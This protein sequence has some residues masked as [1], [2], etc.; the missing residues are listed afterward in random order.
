[1]RASFGVAI[2][3]QDGHNR[4]A[5]LNNAD[6]AMNRAK[7]TRGEP[8]CYYEQ[9]MDEHARTRRRIAGDLHNALAHE[10]LCLFY[11]PQHSVRT[12]ALTGYEALVRWRHRCA[13]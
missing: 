13:A 7:S 2:F 3:P 12:G 8:I 1:M 11:Q 10:E 9:G 5:L 6:L 4:E